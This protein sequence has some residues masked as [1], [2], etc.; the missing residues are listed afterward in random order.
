[1]ANFEVNNGIAIIPEGTTTIEAQ[2][3]ENCI[4][5]KSVVIPEGVTEIGYKAFCGCSSLR[6]IEIP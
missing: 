2:A 1:M 6:S 5:L 3:F 4:E